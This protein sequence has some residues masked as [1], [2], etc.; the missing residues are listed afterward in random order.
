MSDMAPNAVQQLLSPGL[1]K[2]VTLAY[3]S[4]W[5]DNYESIT[6]FLSRIGQ[7]ILEV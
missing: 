6:T 2:A 7:N 3:G 4:I 5:D 1:L